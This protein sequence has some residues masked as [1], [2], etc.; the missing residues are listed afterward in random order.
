MAQAGQTL[1]CVG[2]LVEVVINYF[3]KMIL[4]NYKLIL[5]FQKNQKKKKVDVQKDYL[6]LCLFLQKYKAKQ[7]VS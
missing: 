4:R 2:F 6:F 1:R 3:F 5:Y 7:I